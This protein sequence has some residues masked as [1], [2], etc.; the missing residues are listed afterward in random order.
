[1]STKRKI[2][3]PPAFQHQ[4]QPVTLDK[5]G[6]ATTLF[7]LRYLQENYETSGIE[8]SEH[9]KGESFTPLSPVEIDRLCELINT[10]DV[11]MWPMRKKGI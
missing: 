9:F 2:K 7:A 10:R 1:M 3:D 5:A 8:S 4:T 6:L 11:I